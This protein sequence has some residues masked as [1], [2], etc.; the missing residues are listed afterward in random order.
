[1]LQ[2]THIYF[3]GESPFWKNSP[4]YLEGPQNKLSILNVN[5]DYLSFLFK[6]KLHV[7]THP[8]K[9]IVTSSS[10]H[11][12]KNATFI[13]TVMFFY[14]PI[15]ISPFNKFYL[16]SNKFYL[17]SKK[18]KKNTCLVQKQNVNKLEK[19]LPLKSERGSFPIFFHP[20]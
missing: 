4:I 16:T 20:A 12:P 2:A 13:C 6:K 1:M 10:A 3:A 17:T 5:M 15:L 14:W 8:S 18:K 9:H 11:T 19:W 7:Y